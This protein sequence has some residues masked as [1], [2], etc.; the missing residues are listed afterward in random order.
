MENN[1]EPEVIDS[2]ELRPKLSLQKAGQLCVL[3][4]KAC[5]ID[6]LTLWQD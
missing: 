5:G 4:G 1:P 6:L 2:T 3:A